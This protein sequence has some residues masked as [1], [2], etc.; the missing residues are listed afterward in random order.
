MAVA[1]GT[2]LGPYEILSPLGAGG[3]GEVYRARDI[4]LDRTVAVK[5]LPAH[6]ADDPDRIARCDAARQA[7]QARFDRE[8]E[9]ARAHAR[10]EH[11]FAGAQGA[12]RAALAA[13]VAAGGCDGAESQPVHAPRDPDE[14]ARKYEHQ[15]RST[16]PRPQA[17]SATSFRLFTSA[18]MN[19]GSSRP[20][21]NSLMLCARISGNRSSLR[22]LKS[23]S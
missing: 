9:E 4:R 10:L 8:H 22:P 17:I 19:S 1:V 3:M 15:A 13:L 21:P 20:S 5:V 18:T 12:A 16:K 7:L 11:E 2:R 14:A 23:H 6:L